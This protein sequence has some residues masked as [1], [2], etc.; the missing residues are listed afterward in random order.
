MVMMLLSVSTSA[1]VSLLL[2]ASPTSKRGLGEHTLLLL[3]VPSVS[4]SIHL[5]AASL[6]TVCQG[7]IVLISIVD[8]PISLDLTGAYTSWCNGSGPGFHNVIRVI[9]DL[10]WRLLYLLDLHIQLIR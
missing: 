6:H 3:W 2:S 7:V 1:C 10:I 8:G 4:L 5:L 9:I